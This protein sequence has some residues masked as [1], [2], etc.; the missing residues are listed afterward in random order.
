MHLFAT[1]EYE[2]LSSEQLF[3][4]WNCSKVNILFIQAG[5][6]D[7]RDETLKTAEMRSCLVQ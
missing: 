1:E 3:A 5:L 4:T 2:G 6:I 7:L